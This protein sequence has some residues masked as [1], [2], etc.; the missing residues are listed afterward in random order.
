MPSIE[1]SFKLNKA[2]M[3]GLASAIQQNLESDLSGAF[4]DR[5]YNEFI[6]SPVDINFDNLQQVKENSRRQNA[7]DWFSKMITSGPA[8]ASS[9]S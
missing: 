3:Q 6:K 1:K 5:T 9:D 8:P 7:G 2:T 4:G